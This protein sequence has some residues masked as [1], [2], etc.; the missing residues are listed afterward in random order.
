MIL[1]ECL[2]QLARGKLSNLALASEGYIK[3]TFLLKVLDAFNEAYSRVN[4][5]LNLNVGRFK[6]KYTPT[7]T[8]YVLTTEHLITNGE[9]PEEFYIEEFLEDSFKDDL[10]SILSIKDNLNN[11]LPLN[12]SANVNSLFFSFPNVL[13]IPKLHKDV[14]ELEILYRK[15]PKP[16]DLSSFE[17]EINI[18]DNALGAL[19]S[20]TAFLIHSDMNG[21]NAVQNAQKYLSEY[22][23]IINQI[24]SENTIQESIQTVKSKFN[25]RGFV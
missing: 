10:S 25:A 21:E 13:S 11:P 7:V 5:A 15:N 17:S 9:N 4:T 23:A 20:Y 1:Q 12:S 8:K 2:N 16:F 3:D 14:K 18:P 24:I 6:I 19:F 22:Q